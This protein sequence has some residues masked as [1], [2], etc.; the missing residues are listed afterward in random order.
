LRQKQIA[1]LIAY[2][3]I[4]VNSATK[5]ANQIKN[6]IGTASTV[7]FGV[8]DEEHLKV[9]CNQLSENIEVVNLSD[10]TTQQKLE[11]KREELYKSHQ[12]L[13]MWRDDIR[14]WWYSKIARSISLGALDSYHQKLVEYKIKSTAYRF[15]LK[16]Q[17]IV[18]IDKLKRL[19]VVT[20]ADR[21]YGIAFPLLYIRSRHETVK[22]VIVEV[23][24]SASER[25][26]LPFATEK[27]KPTFF[28]RYKARNQA[29]FLEA[30]INSKLYLKVP[31]HLALKNLGIDSKYPW[32]MGVHDYVDLYI[33]RRR[34]TDSE[35]VK[36]KTAFVG[37]CI[38]DS[39]YKQDVGSRRLKAVRASQRK[40]LVAMPQ[41]LETPRE[42]S[43]IAYR[44]LQSDSEK[45][46]RALTYYFDEVIICLHPKQTKQHYSFLSDMAKV[47]ISDSSFYDLVGKCDLVLCTES[48]VSKYA[49]LLSKPTIFFIP[50]HWIYHEV[51]SDLARSRE[52]GAVIQSWSDLSDDMLK[53]FINRAQK[54]YESTDYRSDE[55]IQLFDGKVTQR[56]I[57]AIQTL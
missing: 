33:S 29:K 50:S 43:K 8:F 35:N 54:Y 42:F 13:K 24:D 18:K 34:P 55:E 2:P 41:F 31:E 11:I 19:Y 56:V 7:M 17:E 52:W 4:R 23:A 27:I 39:L 51:Y 20:E 36:R 38:S 10:T 21:G 49:W 53:T 30:A 25:D 48:S 5:L 40:I 16:I 6:S 47:S 22:Y 28:N 46:I 37:D 3:R 45:L 44:N 9:A 14:E 12:M 32:R 26:L 15:E 1:F 57:E